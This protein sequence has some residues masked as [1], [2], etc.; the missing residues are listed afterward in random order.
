MA[1]YATLKAAIAAVIKE[2]GNQEITGDIMQSTLLSMVN[3]LGAGY[4]FMGIA[5]PETNPGTPDQNV[6]YIAGAGTYPNF[7]SLIVPDKNI[8]LLSYNGT[9]S[10]QTVP[11]GKDYDAQIGELEQEMNGISEMETDITNLFTW[12]DNKYI[13]ARESH[14]SYGAI[15][16]DSTGTLKA[17]GF[18]KV[19]QYAGKKLRIAFAYDKTA[20]DGQLS[21][22]LCFYTSATSATSVIPGTGVQ[23]P[24]GSLAPYELEVTIPLTARQVKTTY[25]KD[26][27]IVGPFYAKIVEEVDKGTLQEQIDELSD[28]V[29]GMAVQ[30]VPITNYRLD[31]CRINSDGAYSGENS[32]MHGVLPVKEGEVYKLKN[33]GASANIRYA[34]ATSGE[35]VVSAAIPMVAGTSVVT[36]DAG[37]TATIEIP[38]GAK[39]LVFNARPS[40]SYLFTLSKHITGIGRT[41]ALE[42]KTA[43]YEQVSSWLGNPGAR[44]TSINLS[45]DLALA[46][47]PTANK[48]GDKYT[49]GCKVSSF[50]GIKIC[51]G[52][53]TTYGAF[54]EIDGTNVKLYKGT[55]TTTP[56]A[57]VAHGLTISTMLN[58]NIN[59]TNDGKAVLTMQTLGGSFTHTFA[60]W[61][62]NIAGSLVVKNAGSTVSDCV[63]TAT[64]EYFKNPIWIFG[65][66]F[67][68]VSDTRWPGQLKNMGYFNYLLNGYPGRDGRKSIL[69]FEKA[70][71][72]GVPKY[73]YFPSS[74]DA[75]DAIFEQTLIRIMALC[76]T[77]GITLIANLK[78]DNKESNFSVRRTAVINAGCRYVSTY[79]AVQDPSI[80]WSEGTDNWY[81]GFQGSDGV[82][83]TE[84]GAKAIAM[85]F[86]K[87]FPEIAQ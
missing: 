82:H 39:F 21:A 78:A 17:S 31:P 2:N 80:T 42:V 43:N 59:V 32:Y 27:S 85:Q 38:T 35:Y 30:D 87:D 24:L 50:S 65:A 7:S 55:D 52:Y 44:I 10:V 54:F 53:N 71:N 4:Q 5:S 86:L 72:F 13:I 1:Q 68:S 49:F 40:A 79:D 70:L 11:V 51:R 23:F 41:T 3:S 66:S 9:W 69:D 47:Y 64:N 8:G 34:L 83:P 74:N 25:L 16:N 75:S 57:T 48:I 28:D 26:D 84:L 56:V 45:S 6:F 37:A 62:Y 36:V 15:N 19:A 58:V 73:L 46:D 61:S 18:V 12:T 14:A 67:E 22:G 20:S 76:D 33:N 60:D 81:S 77:Y 29:K 63:F